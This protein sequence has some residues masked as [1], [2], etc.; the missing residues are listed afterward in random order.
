MPANIL[1]TTDEILLLLTLRP[2]RTDAGRKV[3]S[4]IKERIIRA[5][6]AQAEAELFG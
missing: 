5:Q 6:I 2:G 3:S 1:K 4:L